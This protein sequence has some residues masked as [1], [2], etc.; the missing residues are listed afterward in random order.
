MKPAIITGHSKCSIDL[1]PR[2]TSHINQGLHL[3]VLQDEVC[4]KSIQIYLDFCTKCLQPTYLWPVVQL[5]VVLILDNFLSILDRKT[6]L[7][8]LTYS[9]RWN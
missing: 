1:N 7:D 5:A 8:D 3:L 2:H 6:R 9:L 4:F